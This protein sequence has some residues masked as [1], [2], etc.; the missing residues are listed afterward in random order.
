MSFFS[1]LIALLL[2]QVR[3]LAQSNGV[4]NLNR[5]WVHW[6]VRQFDTGQRQHAGVAW[7]LVVVLPSLFVCLVHWLLLWSL[8]WMAAVVWHVAVLYMTLGFRQFSHHFTQIRDAL[9]AGEEGAAKKA[10][11]QWMRIDA[12][13][14]PQ[15]EMVRHVIE[16]S[17]VSAHRYVFG[18][19]AWYSFLSALGLGPAG[20]VFYR[21]NEY[22]NRYVHRPARPLAVAVGDEL[23]QY[24]ARLWY[25]I[26]WLPVRMTAL[27]FALVGSFEDTLDGWRAHEKRFPQDND[28]VVLA[29]TAGA[30]NIRLAAS[31][32][33]AA[34]LHQAPQTSHLRSVVGLVWRAV[35]L[36]M[37]F[38]VVL[39]LARWLG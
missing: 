14:L 20:A 39:T 4:H 26:D 21:V 25:V 31:G 19:I 32:D 15:S 30:V 27:V 13:D 36:W 29:A 24:V 6:V 34:P 28:G 12:S 10:L 18:V 16:Y 23:R 11:A 17:V 37:V 22:F 3:P 8:G 2:E 38:L 9:Y 35:V 1:I 7:G 33:D 5:D